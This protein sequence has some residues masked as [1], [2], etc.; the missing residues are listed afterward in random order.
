MASVRSAL[1][2][3]EQR[4]GAAQML[5]KSWEK[6]GFGVVLPLEEPS[7]RSEGEIGVCKSAISDQH[8][9]RTLKSCFESRRSS[10]CAGAMA[11]RQVPS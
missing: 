11:V 4:A 10:L 3:T 1:S 8:R 2:T 6:P 7:K 9:Q 5:E